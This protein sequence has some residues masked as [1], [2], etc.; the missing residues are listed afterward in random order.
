MIIKQ[1]DNSFYEILCADPENEQLITSSMPLNK[2]DLDR[3]FQSLYG[4]E[5]V[6]PETAQ[7]REI[8]PL[9]GKEALEAKARIVIALKKYGL[10]AINQ[11]LKGEA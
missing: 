11:I 1:E 6:I 2:E 9:K 3:I 10:D 5:C 4:N 7:I 8:V